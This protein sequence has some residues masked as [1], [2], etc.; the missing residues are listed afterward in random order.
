MQTILQYVP[1]R[2]TKFDLSN[3]ISWEIPSIRTWFYSFNALYMACRWF[4]LWYLF[5]IEGECSFSIRF[6]RREWKRKSFFL[7]CQSFL[8]TYDIFYR[9]FPIQEHW[10][11]WN[12]IEIYTNT[13]NM[14]KGIYRMQVDNSFSTFVLFMMGMLL[15]VDTKISR[16]CLMKMVFYVCTK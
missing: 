5:G 10:L 16:V 7:S 2:H 11:I 9:P 12:G 4:H 15:V 3:T 1:L 13:G 8:S 14:L 6:H